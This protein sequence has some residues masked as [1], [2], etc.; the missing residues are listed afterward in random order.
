MNGFSVAYPA[1]FGTD[2]TSLLKTNMVKMIGDCGYAFNGT[3]K[4]PNCTGFYHHKDKTCILWSLQQEYFYW[5]LT[6]ILGAQD[7]PLAPEGRCKKIATEWELCNKAKVKEYNS[8]GY[9]LMTDEKFRL[10]T[11]LPNGKYEPKSD[12]T[13][14]FLK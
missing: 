8:A 2:T 4:W 6:S 3:F 11:K 14:F 13:T 9:Q 12:L 7:G 10:P 5:I 1:T